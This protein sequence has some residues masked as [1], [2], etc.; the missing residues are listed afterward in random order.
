MKTTET[1]QPMLERKGWKYFADTSTWSYAGKYGCCEIQVAP[2]NLYGLRLHLNGKSDDGI[3]NFLSVL[4][5]MKYAERRLQ[6]PDGMRLNLWGKT[7]RWGLLLTIL[8]LL[9][10]YPLWVLGIYSV[11]S[12]AIMGAA[13]LAGGLHRKSKLAAF[14]T[15]LLS[16]VVFILLLVLFGFRAPF[17]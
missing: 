14:I 1:T 5:A 15:W 11:A 2:D 16:P 10:F 13:L 3:F 8:V 12:Y 17:I 6:Y 9:F 4:D 7:W